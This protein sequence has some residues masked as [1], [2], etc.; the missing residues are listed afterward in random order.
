MDL[1]A[2]GGLL[3]LE[4]RSGRENIERWGALA[5][6]TLV[7]AGLAGTLV[8]SEFHYSTYGNTRTGNVLTSLR[9]GPLH[10]VRG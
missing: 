5:G 9:V 6:V 7:L 8:L 4:W 3:C 2:A 1:L 10:R